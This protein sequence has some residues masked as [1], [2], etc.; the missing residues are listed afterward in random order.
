MGLVPQTKLQA[1]QIETCVVVT[2]ER[3]PHVSKVDQSKEKGKTKQAT[4]KTP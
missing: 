4:L 1:P 2:L 3:L